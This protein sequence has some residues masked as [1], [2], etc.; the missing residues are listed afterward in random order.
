MV[1][2]AICN[3]CSIVYNIPFSRGAFVFPNSSIE[4]SPGVFTANTTVT[5]ANSPSALTEFYSTYVT[6]VDET[7]ILDATAFKVRELALKYDFSKDMIKSLS[8][9]SASI[10]FSGRNLFTVL[11]KENRGYANPESNFSSGN[12]VGLSD[13]G[14]YPETRTYGVSLNL[15]F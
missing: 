1:I 15:T 2:R 3:I 12:A 13:S 7:E 4:T 11:P 14:Q 9:S 6:A 10:S 8:L 5:S